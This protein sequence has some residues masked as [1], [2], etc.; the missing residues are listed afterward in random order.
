[1]RENVYT[2]VEPM[3]INIEVTQIPQVQLTTMDHH[4]PYENVRY[5]EENPYLSS[6]RADN[7]TK[8][9]KE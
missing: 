9:D 3:L 6:A 1:M 4:E 8:E 5:H 7:L 2:V